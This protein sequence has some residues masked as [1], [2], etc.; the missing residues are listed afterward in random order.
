MKILYFIRHGESEDNVENRWSGTGDPSLTDKGHRQ[1]QKA[2]RKAKQQGLSFDIIVSSPR[3]RA[4]HTAKHIAKQLGYPDDKILI[5]DLFV[6]RHYGVLEGQVNDP[7]HGPGTRY[8]KDE[9]VID[10]HEG[11]ETLEELQARANR[12]LEFLKSLDHDTVLVVAHGATGRALYRAVKNLPIET[13]DIR[14]KNA[15]L[16]RFI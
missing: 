8:F 11:A 16:V 14:Y 4:R 15:D 7:N 1:A 12:A 5:H 6:E 2:G 9:S 13:R 3:K 10:E